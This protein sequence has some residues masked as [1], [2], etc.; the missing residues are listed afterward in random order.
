MPKVRPARRPVHGTADA[1]RELLRFC[2]GNA[3]LSQAIMTMSLPAG[4]FCPFAERCLSRAARTTG[5]ITDGPDTEFRCYA[6]TGEARSTEAR[7]WR[8]RNAE[9]LRTCKSTPE[10]VGLIL[11]S[12]TPLAGYVRVHESGDF[13]SQ[14][15]FDAW[16]TVARLRPRTVIYGYTKSVIY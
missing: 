11:E 9:L 5:R 4:H 14:A 8:W 3:K 6:A 13:F 2:S 7:R 16:L 10:M 15:Y 12:L 1:P